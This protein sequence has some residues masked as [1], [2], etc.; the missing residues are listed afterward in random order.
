MMADHWPP[1][2][3]EPRWDEDIGAVVGVINAVLPGILA[4]I[5]L[6]YVIWRIFW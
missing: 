1:D 3:P 5:V 4:W 6:G 2:E